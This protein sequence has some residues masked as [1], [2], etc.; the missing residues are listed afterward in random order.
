MERFWRTMREKCLNHLGH[1]SSLDD[2]N[3]RLSTFL[4]RHYQDEPHSGLMGAS[5]T[6]VYEPSRLASNPVDDDALREALAVQ[7][8]RR[9]GNDSTLKIEGKLYEL[10]HGYLDG[11]NVTVGYSL[12][13]APL[14][15]WV[16]EDGK[17]L[18]LHLVDVKANGVGRRPPRYEVPPPPM[19]PTGFDPAASCR[20]S[21]NDRTDDET[22]AADESL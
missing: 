15:P 17:R 5:P 18:P 12:L 1:V 13:D 19:T 7:E 22:E 8:R 3:A 4:K 21:S 10:S 14:A 16:E 20:P 9:V 11:R 2:V 6:K